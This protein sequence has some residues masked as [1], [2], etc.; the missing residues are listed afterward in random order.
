MQKCVGIT[1]NGLTIRG[2]LHMPD[3]AKSKVPGV[4]MYHGFTGNCMESHWI[5]VKLSRVLEKAGIASARFDFY[6]SGN[7]DGQFSDMTPQTELNDAKAVLDFMRT[8]DRVDPARIGI[9][10]LSMGGYIAGITAGDNRDIVKS[11]CMWA[12][13]GN[14]KDI[15]KNCMETNIEVGE[16]LYDI[17]GLMLNAAAYRSAAS[18]DHMARTCKFDKDI[19]IIQGT[20]DQS[21]P[22]SV[23]L[24]YKNALD[25]AEF[26]PIK[27]SDHTF[28]RLEWENEVI[29]IT[30]DFFKR[31]L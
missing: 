28:E 29:N 20:N 21:V 31:T 5:F 9:L 19:C 16:G 25:N 2:M 18:I 6:G 30:L 15:F 10:G 7:S 24:K 1:R 3:G 22:Y 14:I 12:P 26:H 23:G 4:V 27:G 11:L 8:N 17:G 13:A